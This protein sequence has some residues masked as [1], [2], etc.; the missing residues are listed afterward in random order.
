MDCPGTQQPGSCLL[1]VHP[2][3]RPISAL[4]VSSMEVHLGMELMQRSSN[5][6]GYSPL[7][8]NKK[9]YQHLSGHCLGDG[10]GRRK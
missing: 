10:G 1:S 3:C 4:A 7:H 9:T 2:C 6:S 8:P 5:S